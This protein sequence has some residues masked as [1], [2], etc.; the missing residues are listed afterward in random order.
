MHAAFNIVYTDTLGH[1]HQQYLEK[2][3]LSYLKGLLEQHAVE[4]SHI[5]KIH[6][7]FLENILH[8]N[9]LMEDYNSSELES[10]FSSRPVVYQATM[11]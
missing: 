10:S 9:A 5:S 4:N 1:E 3:L 6:E 8:A 2:K 11:H 7:Y